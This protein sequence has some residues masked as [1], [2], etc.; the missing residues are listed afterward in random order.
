MP[1]AQYFRVIA[2]N[3]SGGVVASRVVLEEEIERAHDELQAL[4]GVRMCVT[5]GPFRGIKS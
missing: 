4:D 1:P 5:Q 3:S 2:Y